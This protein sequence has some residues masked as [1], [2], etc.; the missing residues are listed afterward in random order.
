[1]EIRLCDFLRTQAPH[2]FE[3]PR[4]TSPSSYTSHGDRGEGRHYHDRGRQRNDQ[5]YAD[6][7]RSER[8]PSSNVAY[9]RFSD[10][11]AS[12]KAPEKQT[13]PIWR[14]KIARNGKKLVDTI[15]IAISGQP[16][17]VLTKDV[18]TI[19]ITHRLKCE[20][21]AK[22]EPIAVFYMKA[23]R[24]EQQRALEDYIT[25]FQDKDRIGVATLDEDTNI[26][27][28]APGTELFKTHA[29][30]GGGDSTLIGIAV[31]ST[32][33]TQEESADKA[34]P[35]QPEERRDW[36]NQLNTLTAMLGAKK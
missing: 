18:N 14:G 2:I 33:P 24:P 21:A 8:E 29:P 28:C 3:R 10:N 26:Y 4:S 31:P 15:A 5:Q 22:V 34:E 12:H 20:D 25:Y 6:T 36:L 23:R 13:Q 30:H 1:M 32:S 27:V 19:N 16:E 11:A 9:N 7:S 35:Q 17:A